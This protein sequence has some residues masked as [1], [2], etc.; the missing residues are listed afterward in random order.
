MVII[1]LEQPPDRE[2]G[3]SRIKALGPVYKAIRPWKRDVDVPIR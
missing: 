3:E 1:A 2:G